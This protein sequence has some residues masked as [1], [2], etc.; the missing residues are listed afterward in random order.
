MAGGSWIHASSTSADV[1]QHSWHVLLNEEGLVLAP[2]RT[3]GIR[4]YRRKTIPWNQQA[5]RKFELFE[6]NGA[7]TVSAW[8]WMITVDVWTLAVV[9][10]SNKQML[11]HGVRQVTNEKAC[12][13]D[14]TCFGSD[15]IINR[16]GRL[17]RNPHGAAPQKAAKHM[18]QICPCRSWP[19]SPNQKRLL[20]FVSVWD[21]RCSSTDQWAPLCW[22]QFLPPAEVPVFW[23]QNIACH[24]RPCPALS[25]WRLSTVSGF[26]VLVSIFGFSA[27]FGFE[28]SQTDLQYLINCVDMCWPGTAM[29]WD[30]DKI[31]Q[32]KAASTFIPACVCVCLMICITPLLCLF[33]LPFT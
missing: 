16:Y 6:S 30:H 31:T 25:F 2:T 1:A 20:L 18:T 19:P 23:T 4:V 17:L 29:S 22:H 26:S 14:L 9:C 15:T 3:G 33:G 5:S 21:P 32:H 8:A 11:W 24:S 12:M 27:S 10:S 13:S 28:A 7:E